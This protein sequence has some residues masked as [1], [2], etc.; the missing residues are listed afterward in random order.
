MFRSLAISLLTTCLALLSLAPCGWNQAR[1]FP[2]VKPGRHA[3]LVGCTEYPNLDKKFWLQGPANDVQL[4]AKLL[5]EKFGFA[6]ESIVILSDEVAR[7]K[8]DDKLYPTRANIEREFKRLATAARA[9]D[10][11]VILMS[12]HGSQAPQIDKPP[13][14]KPDGMCEIFLPREV[15]KWND[16]AGKVENAI[17]DYE[18]AAWL[19]AIE[20]TRASV[21]ITLDSCHSGTGVRDAHNDE[22]TREIDLTRASLIPRE[23]FDRAVERARKK[24]V[25]KRGGPIDPPN[26]FANLTKAPGGL[27]A[28]YA[29]LATQTTLEKKLPLNS[30]DA[31][32]YGLLTYCM[33]ETLLQA[34]EKSDQPLTYRQLV[35]GIQSRY[36]AMG[37]I[38][39]TPLIEGSDADR[40]VLGE[41][42]WPE[43]SSIVFSSGDKGLKV[44][45]GALRGLT[46][47]SILAVYPPPG[48]GD[49]VLGHVRIKQVRTNDADV[50]SVAFAKVKES[51][52]L[53]LQG[54]CKLVFADFGD[55]QLTLAVDPMGM[56]DEVMDEKV[57]QRLIK[58]LAI[59]NEGQPVKEDEPTT[60]GLA[61]LVAR[62]AD[63]DWLLMPHKDGQLVLVAAADK[64]GNHKIEPPRLFGPFPDDDK[65]MELLEHSLVKIIRC[66]NLKKL[67]AGFTEKANDQGVKLKIEMARG[68]DRRNKNDTIPIPLPNSNLTFYDRDVVIFKITNPGREPVDLS[69][70]YLDS[71]FH[72]HCMHPRMNAD[73]RLGPGQT[74]RLPAVVNNLT[75]GIEYM[76]VIG[77]RGEGQTKDFAFLEQA[78]LP[79]VRMVRDRDPLGQLLRKAVFNEGS[80]RG[81]GAAEADDYVLQLLSWRI[82]PEKRPPEIPAEKK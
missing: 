80:A 57:R 63:A 41:K 25:G 27:V 64:A 62:P 22:K 43:R 51:T 28:L 18:F 36:M 29:C 21:W 24:A 14:P 50:E 56:H 7:A 4:M 5:R 13:N 77:V 2:D 30:K 11:V 9:G 42:H 12:G 8:S 39:P 70:L 55:Q 75:I 32:T 16:A 34:S 15:G 1:A 19:G 59:L 65:L 3:L 58:T 40:E 37:K 17:I 35:E 6:A 26:T 71:D 38:F 10:K 69:V 81:I 53:P 44:N 74:F 49:M 72:I 20:K 67:A 60:L 46:R 82:K 47:G 48:Q 54:R 61:R 68:K 52:N 78:G 76:V 73:N 31:R 45:A 66:E 33:V 23:T 79:Q